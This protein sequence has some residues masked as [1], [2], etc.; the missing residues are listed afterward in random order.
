MEEAF[1]RELKE[2]AGIRPSNIRL[3]GEYGYRS[4]ASGVETKR[5]Y[6][7]ADAECAE[8]FTHIVQ[9]ND[10]DNGWIYHYRWTDVEPSLTLYGYLGMMP[11]TIR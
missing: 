1:I 7:E 5:Y 10:E 4:E 9:S 6:F 2:E 8:R 3:L 11:H